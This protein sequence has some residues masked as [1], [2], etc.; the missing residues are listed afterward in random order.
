MKI[1]HVITSLQTGGAEKLMVE[2]IPQLRS[3][4]NDVD[5]LV[6]NGVYTPFYKELERKGVKI[7]S[8]GLY[9]NVY[10]IRN[11]F[12]LIKFLKKHQ[13][14][15]VHTHNTAAQLF[16]ALAKV[17]CSVVLC[18]TEH[19]TFNRRRNWKWYIPFE[20]LMYQC[21]SHIICIS[22]KTEENLRNHIGDIG[23]EIS[24]IYNGV[25]ISKYN[26]AISNERLKL[27]KHK[28]ILCMV[29]GF[30][31]Q[32][33]QDTII[34]SLKYIGKEK[35]ELWLVGDGVRRKE[36]ES[37]VESEGVKDNVVFWGIRSDVP[38]IL[39]TS[40]I[41]IMSSHFEGFGLAAVEG[42]AAGKPIIVSDVDGLSQV[43]GSA[44]LIFPK[45]D[46]KTLASYIRLVSENKLIY[47]DYSRKSIERAKLY[48]ITYMVDSYI[49][50]YKG[51]LNNKL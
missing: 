30:R 46:S 12:N 49:N 24:T 6:F 32:K 21:Y 18:T 34:R 25:N 47:D 23:V 50:V 17:L 2:I 39:K 10:D 43:V 26:N 16:A 9:K 13:Y 11:L 20:R 38:E 33:D 37:L 28:I 31:H 14:D 36:L 29:A 3:L 15:I 5:L 42:M 51:I 40:D 45:G 4:G 1:L 27:N 48:D 44:G 7:F 22:D 35:Y 8:L 19:N 41:V